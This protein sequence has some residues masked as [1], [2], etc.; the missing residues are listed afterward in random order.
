MNLMDVLLFQD[1]KELGKLLQGI[2]S[3]INV[4][5]KRE[6]IEVLYAELTNFHQFS[7]KFQLLSN[8]AKRIALT[9]CFD[10][11]LFLSKEELFGFV[12]KFDQESFHALV[13]E[14]TSCGILFAYANKNYLI[15]IQIKDEL[16]RCF[17]MNMD[18][19][20]FIFPSLEE[21]N[22]E[23]EIVND[24]LSFIDIVVDSPLPLTKNGLIHKKDFQA[25]MKQFSIKETIPD[26]KWRFGYGRRFSYYPDRFSFIYD[27]CF[28]RKWINETD[29]TLV[30]GEKVN[31]LESLKLDIFIQSLV[32]YWLTLYRRP[33]PTIKLLFKLFMGL[34]EDGNGIEEEGIIYEFTPLVTDY[35]YDT[36]EDVIKKRF[37]N[38][39]VNLNIIKPIERNGLRFY[40]VG[41]AK[42][43]L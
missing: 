9:L 42:Y 25:I 43:L 38:M 5:S 15:P 19:H 24:I 17:K 27:F 7:K 35:Y 34:V 11:K 41:P 21:T 2:D 39:L 33:I 12:P 6:M 28:N 4:H 26:E 40:T 31:E 32:N 18:V 30:I 20:S 14:L 22:V 13:E 1:R 36:K 10:E 23:M 8:D 29:G 3:N 16:I 37:I